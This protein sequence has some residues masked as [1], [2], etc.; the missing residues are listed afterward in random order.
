MTS[1]GTSP[2]NGASPL[3]GLDNSQLIALCES[4]AAD[5]TRLELKLS[6]Y[7]RRDFDRRTELAADGYKRSPID[8]K[9]LECK[10]PPGR[11]W[12]IAGWLPMGHVTLLAGRGGIGK[13]LLAQTISSHLCTTQPYVDEIPRPRRVL[14]WAGEDDRG[15]L[16]RRQLAIAKSMDAS[17]ADF[18]DL[19]F[20]ESF[21]DRDMTLAGPEMGSLQ[22]T[23]LMNELASQ[24]ADYKIDY[25]WL[26]SVARIFGGNENDR[27][28]V[29]Q[30]IT[31]LTAAAGAAGIG[32][33]GHPGKGQGSEY[34]GSTAWEGSVRSRLF[35]GNKLPDQ[36]ADDEGD[37]E[38]DVLYLCRRKANYAPQD[39][40]RFRFVEGVLVPETPTE[41]VRFGGQFAQDAVLRAV[42]KLHSMGIRGNSSTR[43][44][45]FL[46]KQAAEYNLLDGLSRKQF[47]R[48]MREA[49][50]S[51]RLKNEVVGQYAN[52][53]DKLGLVE[54]A[55]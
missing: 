32:I 28:Q 12:A 1:T 37:E 22:P 40:R 29:T 33:I 15:E 5:R 36:Q 24:V 45:E 51:G 2:A 17:L 38:S 39:W 19:L 18:E 53:T 54:V 3:A 42:R 52:R 50:K 25:L 35:L 16:W 44:P 47:I 9:A 55:Q 49:I 41:A 14:F 8:W 20:V 48:A 10:S 6:D 21:I 23:A 34:S 43:S 31:W 46:P 7:E 13:T 11:D 30:F 27:H 4:Q 26:D